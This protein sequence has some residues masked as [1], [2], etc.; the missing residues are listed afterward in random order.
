[1]LED[2]WT[3]PYVRAYSIIM[4]IYSALNVRSCAMPVL[5]ARDGE[6]LLRPWL[7]DDIII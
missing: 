7:T 4:V 5:D 6:D 2:V 1:M 3:G